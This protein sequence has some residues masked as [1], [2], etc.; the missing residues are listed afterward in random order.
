M[1]AIDLLREEHQ[2]VRDLY[3]E[4]NRETGAQTAERKAD[5]ASEICERLQAHTD[6]EEKYFYPPLKSAAPDLVEEAT[7]EHDA[8]K[9]AIAD[10]K[11][12]K[13]KGDRQ[14]EFFSTFET[15]M[16]SV[17]HHVEQEEKDLFPV[18]ERELQGRLDEIGGDMLQR[19]QEIQRAA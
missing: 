13:G 14:Q 3:A 17:E 15:M 18:A 11:D 12:I 5:L 1:N 9:Q 7:Q 4:Y 8:L 19:K 6:I 16:Q 2:V 10:L